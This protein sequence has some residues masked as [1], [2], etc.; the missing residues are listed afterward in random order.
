MSKNILKFENNCR[1]PKISLKK[2][3]FIFSKCELHLDV[4]DLGQTSSGFLTK[5]NMR[6]NL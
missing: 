6:W 1:G 2:L 3:I 4:Y 5:G